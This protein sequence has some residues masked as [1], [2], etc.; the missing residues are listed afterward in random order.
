MF[1]KP[2]VGYLQKLYTRTLAMTSISSPSPLDQPRS[3][4]KRQQELNKIIYNFTSL[5]KTTVRKGKSLKWLKALVEKVS[6]SSDS[7]NLDSYMTTLMDCSK[8]AM[9]QF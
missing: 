2:L 9:T 8:R 7:A 4:K 1:D 3:P 6:A 5:P